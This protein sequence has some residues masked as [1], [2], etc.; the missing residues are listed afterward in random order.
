MQKPIFET[1]P[2]SI[3]VVAVEG[4]EGLA[5]WV[6]AWE[7][8]AA[9]TIEPNVFYEPWQVL[10]AVDEFGKRSH[11]VHLLV[12]SEN[13]LCAYF[14]LE[15][16]R[17]FRGVPVP[18][19]TLWK[20]L[21]CF[22]CTPLIRPGYAMQSLT[23]VLEWARAD[24]CGAAVVQF[25]QVAGDGPFGCA[26]RGF[27]R[28]RRRPSFSFGTH[29][30]ALFVPRDDAEQY[31]LSAVSAKS[32]KQ[33][34]RLTRRISEIGSV[35]FKVLDPSGDLDAWVEDFL[36][37]EAS[38]WKGRADSALACHESQ[39]RFFKKITREAFDRDRLMLLAMHLNGRPV[40][41]KCNLLAGSA[42]FAFKIAF[43]E[44]LA[45]FSPG[46]LLEIENIRRLHAKPGLRWMDSC[47]VADHS[48]ANRLWIDRRMIQTFAIA[49]GRPMGDLFVSAMPLVR[50]LAHRFVRPRRAESVE[51]DAGESP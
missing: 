43:D 39:R 31:L 13:L 30:R 12:F 25:P 1:T 5:E 46:V 16:L 36:R 44:A 35:E 8:L 40:A 14:P 15:R 51:A 26:L 3:S 48:M 6:P 45:R 37:L 32:R 50:W 47:A 33:L 28:E 27:L 18:V 42:S 11:I 23:A 9:A 19:L 20:H 21:H 17:R 29:D 34:R 7:E 4:T 41:M 2:G 24:P 38:G 49:S 10:P 22:L